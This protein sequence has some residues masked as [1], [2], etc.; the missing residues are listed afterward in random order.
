MS[1]LNPPSY[2]K[3]SEQYSKTTSGA[4]I[5]TAMAILIDSM[6]RMIQKGNR[7]KSGL[8]NQGKR[9]YINGN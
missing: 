1:I 3:P 9:E 6:V 4:E 2:E 8:N 5:P 7:N